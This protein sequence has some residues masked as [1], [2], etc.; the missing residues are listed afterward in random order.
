M[1]ELLGEGAMGTVYAATDSRG[2]RVAVKFLHEGLADDAEAVARFRREAENCRRIRSEYVARVIGAGRSG[3]A[4][5][6]AYKR[7]TGETLAV[8]LRRERVL[9]QADALRVVEQILLGLQAA[10][11]VGVVHRDVKPAN[12]ILE[13]VARGER[14]CILDFGAS[15]FRSQG[16]GGSADRA[17]T[18]ATATLGTVN[19]MPPEQFGGAAGVDARADLYAAGVVAFRALSGQLPFVRQS[20]AAVMQA[21]L[22]AR[23]RTLAEATGVAWPAPVERFSRRALARE[24]AKRFTSAD[25]MRSAWIEAV[26]EAKV[27]TRAELR[28]DEHDAADNGEDTNLDGDTATGTSDVA[29]DREEGGPSSTA[30]PRGTRR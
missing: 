8:R 26:A 13:R 24:A 9:S 14:A 29:P 10:H 18:S 19:Y 6:I 17:L 2:Q 22:T 16:S 5:W 21:K 23:A 25:E 20:Q 30:T 3:D 4:Y 11:A 15:K 7:L 1:G 12:V 27:P 28:A